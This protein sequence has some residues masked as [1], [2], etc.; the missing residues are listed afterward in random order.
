MSRATSTLNALKAENLMAGSYVLTQIDSLRAALRYTTNGETVSY[1]DY[2]LKLQNEIEALPRLKLDT[3]VATGTENQYIMQLVK[4]LEE[5][6]DNADRTV[7]RVLHYQSK[8]RNAM[9]RISKLRAAFSAWYTLA[10][11]ESLE[12]NGA[13]FPSNQLKDLASSEFSRL[14]EGLDV[15]VESLSEAV[16]VQTEQIK[17]WK[18]TQQE[19]FNL[20]KDQ[21]NASWTSGLPNF[22]EGDRSD[23][24]LEKNTFEEEV[25]DEVPAFVSTKP[26]VTEAIVTA[27]SE[28]RLAG[29]PEP[30]PEALAS[31]RP[32]LE[33]LQAENAVE[34]AK[35]PTGV[36]V[37]RS[38]I[39]GTF[40]KQGP[41]VAIT[42]IVNDDAA[43]DI[44]KA[45]P[46]LQPAFVPDPPAPVADLTSVFATATEVKP[47]PVPATAAPKAPKKHKDALAYRVPTD[48]ETIVLR[49][50]DPAEKIK[51][52]VCDRRIRSKQEMFT[53][54]SGWAHVNEGECIG[55]PVYPHRK[56]LDEPGGVMAVS[57]EILAASGGDP[58]NQAAIVATAVT[59][60]KA[61]AAAQ[62]EPGTILEALEAPVL[63]KGTSVL[64]SGTTSDNPPETKPLEATVPEVPNV[65]AP[66]TPR[67]RLTFLEDD[68][69][70]M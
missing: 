63:G 22:G 56:H 65:D 14:M 1:D 62:S 29:L 20:G 58:N 12:E 43:M 44:D 23:Q 37:D 60:M 34:D 17:Q 68:Q 25:D 26:S 61:V 11:G 59:Q 28:I 3:V 32:T 4:G 55:A 45:A 6:F 9:S 36:I 31:V 27:K 2:Y 38:K 53:R 40:F 10:A 5:I 46:V 51:C 67:K 33:K 57:P 64:V 41:A 21:A 35:K 52:V 7:R 50:S 66:A 30:S 47:A 18:K 70:I 54:D 48:G 69:E 19:K 16:K 13:K 49:D 42:P 39:Q 15:E 24:L 8:L